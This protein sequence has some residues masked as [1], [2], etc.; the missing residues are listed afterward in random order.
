MIMYLNSE[1]TC[2]C[3]K[4]LGD[5]LHQNLSHLNLLMNL[6]LIFCVPVYNTTNMYILQKKK[7][8][9]V[10]YL[11]CLY[12]F[13]ELSEKIPSALLTA[14]ACVPEWSG[15]DCPVMIAVDASALKNNYEK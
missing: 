2:Y 12:I 5:F 13:S 14:S 4:S 9:M 3:T 10:L 6:V 15:C 11:F 8:Y 7:L 1:H